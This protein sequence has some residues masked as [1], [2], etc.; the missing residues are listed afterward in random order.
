MYSDEK[1]DILVARYTLKRRRALLATLQDRKR[2]K[3][4]KEAMKGVQ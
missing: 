1:F 2:E 4:R 3:R